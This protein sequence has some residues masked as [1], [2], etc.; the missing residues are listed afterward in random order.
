MVGVGW[1]SED[2]NDPCED[3]CELYEISYTDEVELGD[4]ET[5]LKKKKTLLLQ[6]TVSNFGPEKSSNYGRKFV[7][8]LS[9][10]TA[11]YYICV[12]LMFSS[13]QLCRYNERL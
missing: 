5:I 7:S 3:D 9:I 1:I 4:G 6:Y 2:V 12:K 10:C 11:G 8:Y 13:L